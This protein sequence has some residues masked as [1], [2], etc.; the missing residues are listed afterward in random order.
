MN[1]PEDDFGK[2]LM[3][4]FKAKPKTTAE[5]I[6]ESIN[7]IRKSAEQIKHNGEAKQ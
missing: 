4:M 2:R 6:Q 3:D 1:K 5:K 7:K